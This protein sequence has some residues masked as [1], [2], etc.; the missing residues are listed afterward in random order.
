M[1]EE[2]GHE[3]WV[4]N[5]LRAIGTDDRQIA[6]YRPSAFNQALNGY[7]YWVADRGHPCATLGM[8]YCLE[9]IASVY[10][11]PFSNAIQESLLLDGTD[12]VSFIGSHASMDA[13]HM[14]DLRKVINTIGDRETL[15]SIV[16]TTTINFHHFTQ[17]IAAV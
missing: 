2:K 16:E 5:D 1:Q 13:E 11:G 7:N 9:V 10:G 3:L 6:S 12:G 15:Y 14:A 8:L 17:I 4:L